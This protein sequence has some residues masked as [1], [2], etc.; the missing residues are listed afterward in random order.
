MLAEQ[1]TPEAVNFMAREGR[2]LICLAV[3]AAHPD[4]WRKY[5][6]RDGGV[7]GISSF[8]ESAP[9]KALFKEFGFTDEWSVEY[10]HELLQVGGGKERIARQHKQKKLTAR[11][12]IEPAGA[13][14]DPFLRVELENLTRS[15]ARAG[16]VC[17]TTS[18][19][20]ASAGRSSPRTSSHR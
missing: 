11:E 13:L 15:G 2:G 8:G 4:F 7:V 14:P 1:V 10:Y 12:R 19:Y 20:A 5:V 3:E 6:G 18:P 9:D 16:C 17:R